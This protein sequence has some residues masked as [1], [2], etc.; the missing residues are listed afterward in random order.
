MARKDQDKD[1]VKLERLAEIRKFRED[2]ASRNYQEAFQEMTEY[3]NMMNDK[4]KNIDIFL[5]E[6]NTQIQILQNKI[7]TEAVSGQII[8]KYLHL[9]ED[10]QLH[11][12]AKYKELEDKSQGYYDLLDKVNKSYVEFE[13]ISKSRVKFEKLA[14]EKRKIYEDDLDLAE[15]EEIQEQ[16]VF[17]PKKEIDDS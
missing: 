3:Q 14:Q 2:K 4:K 10:T 7:R 13:L 17:R 12:N 6:R 8:Q 15:D 1:H 5:N 11:A 16:F 9:Q